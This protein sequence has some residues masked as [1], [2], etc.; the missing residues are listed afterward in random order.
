MNIVSS[1]N[2][3]NVELYNKV[4]KESLNIFSYL[5]QSIGQFPKLLDENFKALEETKNYLINISLPNKYV[6]AKHIHDIPGWTC[7][8]C[9][10]YTDSIFCHECYKKSKHLHKGHHLYF[11]LNSGGMCGCG[12]PE[13]LQTF[14]PDHS[15]PHMTQELIDEYISK[16]FNEELLKKLKNFFDDIFERLSYYFILTEKCDLFCNE[17][18]HKNFKFAIGLPEIINREKIFITQLKELFKGIFE[19][20]LCFLESITQ[21]NL[22]MLYLISNYFMKNHFNKPS[23]EEDYKIDHRCIKFDI[24]NLEIIKSETKSHKCQCPFFTLLILNWRDDIDNFDNLLLSFT[25]NFPL[26][27]AFGIIYFSFYDRILQNNN[28]NFISNR[29]QFILD[30]STKIL[31]EKTNIIEETYDLFYKYLSDQIKNYPNNDYLY[32]KLYDYARIVDY[33]CNLFSMP[34]T[35]NLMHNKI[36]MIKRIIDCI[37]LIHK[38]LKFKSIY[39]HPMFQDKGYS[40]KL[41]ILE[42]KLLNIIESINMITDWKDMKNIKEIF[43]YIINKIINQES[44]EIHELKKD[45]FSFHLGLYRAFGLLINYFFFYYS[46]NNNCNII[47]SFEFFEQ[48]FFES[49]KELEILIDII[50]NDYFKLFGFIS[51]TKNGF[52]NYYDS[53][54]SYA[55]TYFFDQQLLKID[56][57]LLKY[58]FSM[59]ENNF[60]LYD[61][62]KKANIENAFSFF[63][64]VILLN[65]YNFNQISKIINRETNT[66]SDDL[67]DLLNNSSDIFPPAINYGNNLQLIQALHEGLNTQINPNIIQNYIQGIYD[68]TIELKNINMDIDEFNSIM[69][70]K[71]LLNILIIIIKDDST[72]YYNLMRYYKNTSSSHKKRELF[73]YIKIN[74][75]AMTDLNNIIKEKLI[76][77]FV[78]K[79]NLNNTNKIM[80]HIDSYLFNIFDEKEINDIL[81]ELSFNKKIGNNQL[82]YLKDF[83]FKF[84][85]MSY[86]YSYKDSSNAQ[87]YIYDFKKD[88]V[89]SYN[90]YFYKPSVLMFGFFEKV[91]EK[92][93]LNKNNIEFIYQIISKLLSNKK[94]NDIINSI[95]YIILPD[96][97]K[98]LSIFGCINTKLFIEF[99]IKNGELINKIIQILSDSI[100]DNNKSKNTNFENNINDVINQLNAFKLIK[101]DLSKLNEY[102][103][104][105]EFIEK[106]NEINNSKNEIKSNKIG[107]NKNKLKNIKEKL[108]I[109][110]NNKIKFFLENIKNDEEIS[111]EMNNQNDLEE[112]Y[113]EQNET[114][115]FLCRNKIK[116]NS[117]DEPYGKG[118]YIFSDYFYSNSLNSSIKSELKKLNKD[119]NDENILNGEKNHNLS[120]KII[121]CGHYF[122]FSCFKE[123]YEDTFPCPLCLKSKNILIPPLNN[124]HGVYN[125]LKP[126]T[127]E[128]LLNNK[129]GEIDDFTLFGEIINDFLS[130]FLNYSEDDD[131][132]KKIVIIFK[133]N[134]NYLEN[135]FYYKAT[136]FHKLQQIK[137]NQ[138]F[139]LSI[140]YI[141]KNDIINSNDIINIIIEKLSYLVQGP[142]EEDNILKNYENKYYMDTLEQILLYLAVLFD[143]DIIK[144]LVL[145]SI[146]I[147]LPYIIFGFYLKDLIVNSN[148]FPCLDEKILENLSYDNLKEYIEKHNDQLMDS[149]K[150]FLQKLC[151]IKFI[152]DYNKQDDNIINKFNELNIS[153]YLTLLDIN[154]FNCENNINNIKINT[155]LEILFKSI[156]INKIFNGKLGNE[157]EHI[158]ILNLLIKNIKNMKIDEHLIKNELLLQ[159]SPVKFNFIK[160]EENLFDFIEKYLEKKCVLCNEISRYFYICLICGNKICHTIKCSKFYRHALNCGGKYCI[161]IDFDNEKMII[162]DKKKKE[163]SSLYINKQGIG[164]SSRKIGNDFKLDKEKVE[165]YFRNFI[166]YDFQ[167]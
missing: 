16:T 62:F 136:N 154:I 1:Q 138:N 127:I 28:T 137:I 149:F 99:K 44:E 118:G 56:I 153:E 104:N 143:Y 144:D 93:L 97:L 96:I 2:I 63:E 111:N 40:S 54:N 55:R 128:S 102:D 68:D 162:A 100:S 66:T 14:C 158:K 31:A 42:I 117:F 7:K 109:K 115:C 113:D 123:K 27:H 112:N 71:F 82:Y 24:K 125:Y 110:I 17:I 21:D 12:E 10:K 5:K 145:Y 121:S 77:E 59:T 49:K 74:K 3:K 76:H 84:F 67:I 160:L 163:L 70:I 95:K 57:T 92:I 60:N 41:I 130:D 146:Y 161:F 36:S 47:N 73:N 11:I 87:K 148:L 37:C 94:D 140:R 89:K 108:K 156:N 30:Y 65:N 78:S 114:M 103:Y 85:D 131:I 39:P 61:F 32:E 135:L 167:I 116:L 15:G 9:G 86:Y 122:H 51:G 29:I 79:G 165:E 134:L 69:H 58:L 166:C 19:Y 142:K 129:G 155:I 18:F 119:N 101:D 106:L 6:C 83:N 164:P 22:G 141:A 107:K 139:I 53:M 159:F 13:A 150:L 50:F 132:I 80:E 152:T 75:N 38:K 20:F 25:K 90:T 88:F 105:F 45:E 26:K 126:Y 147:F 4:Y 98:Y 23:I 64:K 52:F 34:E 120:I 33:D 81:D 91:Y 48:N 157:Y 43:R 133:S 8:D 46:F 151:L 35:N 124:F 72:P